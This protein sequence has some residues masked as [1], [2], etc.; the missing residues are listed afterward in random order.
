MCLKPLAKRLEKEEGRKIVFVITDGS[1][2]DAFVK[3]HWYKKMIRSGVQV[4]PVRIGHG[5]WGEGEKMMGMNPG[6]PVVDIK[7][8]EPVLAE[9]IKTTLKESR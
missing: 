8:L 9:A 3:E 1:F 4:L 5:Y 6:K 7:D 2:R